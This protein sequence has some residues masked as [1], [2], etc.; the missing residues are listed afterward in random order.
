[1]GEV[2]CTICGRRQHE[3]CVALDD[4][5]VECARRWK[6]S[7]QTAAKGSMNEL[8]RKSVTI[9]IRRTSQC[10]WK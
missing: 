1:M 10:T 9:H 8:L 5:C 2:K 4:M 3:S 6:V 7:R